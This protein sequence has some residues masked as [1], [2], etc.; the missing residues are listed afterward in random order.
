M[1]AMTKCSLFAAAAL[2]VAALAGVTVVTITPAR[3]ADATVKIDNFSFAPTTLCREDWHYGHLG[4][5]GRYP[6]YRRLQ[7]QALQVERARYRRQVLVHVH[8]TRR[9]PVL[10]LFAPAHDRN[11]RG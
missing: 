7:H 2:Q 10:L 1:N 8:D 3:A 5:R 4:Q 11:D 9:L 6:T